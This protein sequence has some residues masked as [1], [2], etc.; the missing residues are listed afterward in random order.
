MSRPMYLIKPARNESVIAWLLNYSIREHGHAPNCHLWGEKSDLAVAACLTRERHG[1]Q[2][3]V[4]Y[5]MLELHDARQ[6]CGDAAVPCRWFWVP[7]TYVKT[8]M[9]GQEIK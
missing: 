9:H 6:R 3:R 4:C 1:P 7:I 8:F 5:S 2:A